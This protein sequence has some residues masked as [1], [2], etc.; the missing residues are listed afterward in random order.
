MPDFTRTYVETGLEVLVERPDARCITMD[1]VAAAIMTPN[2]RQHPDDIACDARISTFY[3]P[4]RFLFFA[5]AIKNVC[6]YIC[7]NIILL[8]G[9]YMDVKWKI[10]SWKQGFLPQR[11]PPQSDKLYSA[12]RFTNF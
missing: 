7:I 1:D 5:R 3:L 6:F 8:Y 12:G 9:H 4:E 2:F 11:S 10:T